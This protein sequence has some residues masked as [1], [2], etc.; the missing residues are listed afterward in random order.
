MK[1]KKKKRKKQVKVAMI[2]LIDRQ[3]SRKRYQM[4]FSIEVVR[5]HV[6][7]SVRM[8]QWPFKDRSLKLR[9]RL[10]KEVD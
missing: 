9:G 8:I 2:F 7:R 3:V 6:K 10:T 4:G 5:K 1:V